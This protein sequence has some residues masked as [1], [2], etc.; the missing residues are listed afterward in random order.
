MLQDIEAFNEI[1]WRSEAY[2]N[3]PPTTAQ[4][5][6]R[7]PVQEVT[8]PAETEQRLTN[9]LPYYRWYLILKPVAVI[10]TSPPICGNIVA[11][12]LFFVV[13]GVVRPVRLAF[14]L[15]SYQWHLYSCPLLIY[16]GS[17]MSLRDRV[18]PHQVHCTDLFS[19]GSEPNFSFILIGL[20][21]LYLLSVRNSR[22][23][24]PTN[25]SCQ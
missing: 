14:T 11:V 10:I 2:L 20:W 3:S 5:F 15:P 22:D 25:F 21:Q 23:G 7:K 4:R 16:H 9:P 13:F 18:T 19:I 1:T 6:V 12:L 8:H 24:C 17:E